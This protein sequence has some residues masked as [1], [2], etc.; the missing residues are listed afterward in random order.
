[1]HLQS[2]S[3]H[4]QAVI[5]GSAVA[6]W[7]YVPAQ[8]DQCALGAGLTLRYTRSLE[9]G[10][11][12]PSGSHSLTH[13][14]GRWNVVRVAHPLLVT[15]PVAVHRHQR[16]TM[17]WLG[18]FHSMQFEHIYVTVLYDRDRHLSSTHHQLAWLEMA[19]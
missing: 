6:H 14:F 15:L 1:M 5:H 16:C 12:E 11:A 18:S 9:P 3:L 8:Q 19:G 17:W 2:P 4:M 13:T 10:A 7:S